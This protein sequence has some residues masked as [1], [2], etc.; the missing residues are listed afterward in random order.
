[1]AASCSIECRFESGPDPEHPSRHLGV[2]ELVP[3]RSRF[4]WSARR[5][6]TS[7][8]NSV[9]MARGWCISPARPTGTRCIS[10]LP[11]ARCPRADLDRD[12]ATQPRLRRDGKELFYVAFDHWMMAVPI[13][14]SA[15]ARSV[16][17]GTPV[18]LFKAK[19]GGPE[20]G[21]SAEI[22]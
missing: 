7:I 12:G 8:R 5:M 13:A 19:I 17:A 22:E 10:A 16:E 20:S 1:M 4:R 3:G 18:R 15:H 6:K 2:A 11:G 9:P 14:V 21:V